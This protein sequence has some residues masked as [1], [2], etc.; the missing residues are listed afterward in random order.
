MTFTANQLYRT[1]NGLKVRIYHVYEDRIHGATEEASGWTSVSWFTDGRASLSGRHKLDIV[2]LW[3][4]PT[5]LF[6]DSFLQAISRV[7]GR[8]ERWF[9]EGR[10]LKEVAEI[11]AKDGLRMVLDRELP[12]PSVEPV[13]S[14]GRYRITRTHDVCTGDV[15]LCMGIP[16]FR[17]DGHHSTQS[18][19]SLI[20]E[21]WTFHFIGEQPKPQGKYQG[22]NP[23]EKLHPGEPY[24]FLRAQDQ[25]APETVRK[26]AQMLRI[27]KLYKSSAECMRIANQMVTWQDQNPSLTKLPD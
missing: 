14:P 19:E 11:L 2:S 10:P 21:G 23:L 20:Q 12:N 25:L 15:E 22:T 27:A 24:F 13:L 5:D 17:R 7:G 4:E 6:W 8:A 18:V 9:W 1:R 3:Q 26:Y 16:F